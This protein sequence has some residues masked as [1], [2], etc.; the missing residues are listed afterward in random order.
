MEFERKL[1]SKGTFDTWSEHKEYQTAT[2]WLTLKRTKSPIPTVELDE[3]SFY[4]AYSDWSTPIEFALGA[5]A[6]QNPSVVATVWCYSTGPT[7][8]VN[9]SHGKHHQQNG[10]HNATFFGVVGKQE[11]LDVIRFAVT[12]QKDVP[13]S[14]VEQN[15]VDASERKQV[16]CDHS[17][18]YIAFGPNKGV[19]FRHVEDGRVWA[20]EDAVAWYTNP[21]WSA[22]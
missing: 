8:S 15:V 12:G 9:G 5:Y 6:R 20:P 1:K 17:P 11:I 22:G 2:G 7:P 14:V 21:D 3:T 18:D 13:P 16:Y 19:P 4:A 10:W